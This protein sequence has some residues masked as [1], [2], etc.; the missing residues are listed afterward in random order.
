MLGMPKREMTSQNSSFKNNFCMTPVQI[1]TGLAWCSEKFAQAERVPGYGAGP[2]CCIVGGGLWSSARSRGPGPKVLQQQ[3]GG[4][5]QPHSFG[6]S[7]LSSA[8]R[9]PTSRPAVVLPGG[10]GPGAGVTGCRPT[11]DSSVGLAGKR[12]PE[13]PPAPAYEVILIIMAKM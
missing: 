1:V 2:V 11:S 9:V 4:G 6:E 13:V 3:A 7:A 8:A 12:A 5:G 10:W